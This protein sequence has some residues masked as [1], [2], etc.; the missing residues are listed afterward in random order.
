[1]RASAPAFRTGFPSAS[2]RGKG[3]KARNASRPFGRVGFCTKW[4]AALLA[5]SLLAACVS[6]P[7]RRPAPTVDD[8]LARHEAARRAA[9][10]D[11]SLSGRVAIANGRQG[12]SGRIDWTQHGDR[13]RISLAAPVTRQS[14]R[15]DGD[16]AS[17]RLEG[18]EGGPRESADAEALLREATGWSIPVRALVDWVRGI[19]A[20]PT[21]LGEARIDY[22]ANGLPSSVE[23]AGWRIDYRDWYEAG[24]GQP[25]LPKR[26]EARRGESKVRLIVD[27]WT[28]AAQPVPREAADEATPD[29]Q[30]E[31]ALQGLDL[32]DP[33]ADMRANVEAGDLRPVG[34]CGFACLAPGYGAGGAT[35]TRG[36]D[37]RILDGSG[38]VI[39]GD[40]HLALKRRA[41]AY[42]R[43]YNQALAAW[44]EAHPGAPRPVD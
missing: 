17:A 32:D 27:G 13:Y 31:R 26:I 1:M 10:A 20:P 22:A 28:T 18:I 44:R 29:A 9:L 37:M 39:R 14:W 6:S 35:A 30:L 41:E 40:R 12:G 21:A 38:D 33:A 7:V 42:A 11:W 43:A 2:G 4:S 36:A 34:V 24:I 8:A 19:A 23:Q 5:A 15:L 3:P 25:A 16:A